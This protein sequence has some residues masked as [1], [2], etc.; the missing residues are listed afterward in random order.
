M[1]TWSDK[2]IWWDSVA[3]IKEARTKKLIQVVT[4]S[5]NNSSEKIKDSDMNLED[6]RGD[7]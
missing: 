7:S 2:G 6:E 3:T 5:K 4:L 1:S